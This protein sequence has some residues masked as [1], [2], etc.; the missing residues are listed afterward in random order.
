MLLPLD[1]QG[2]VSS[3]TIGLGVGIEV[4]EPMVCSPSTTYALAQLLPGGGLGGTQ[5][6]QHVVLASASSDRWPIF[7]CPK[8]YGHQS[9]CCLSAQPWGVLPANHSLGFPSVQGFGQRCSYT[10]PAPAMAKCVGSGP[11]TRGGKREFLSSPPIAPLI[12]SQ[13]GSCRLWDP[14]SP[15]KVSVGLCM[16]VE[17]HCC[18]HQRS[19]CLTI[20]G[21]A[22]A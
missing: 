21:E 20:P 6:W 8:C 14:V 7:I 1:S 3:P 12:S 17:Y 19:A 10:F 2:I 16:D 18:L 5:C 4:L 9:N 11:K 13:L 22:C 15:Q